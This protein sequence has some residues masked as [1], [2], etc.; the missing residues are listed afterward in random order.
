MDNQ[1]VDVETG[2]VQRLQINTSPGSL[3]YTGKSRFNGR[4]SFGDATIPSR[5]FDVSR[6]N[7]KDNEGRDEL[8]WV[9]G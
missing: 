3:R 5:D 6:L 8:N 2:L 4:F 9:L 1:Q 7:R